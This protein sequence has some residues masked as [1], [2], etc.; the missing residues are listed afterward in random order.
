MKKK[1]ALQQFIEILE[2]RPELDDPKLLFN[3]CKELA[4]EQLLTEREQIE[5]A[6][7]HGHDERDRAGM[8]HVSETMASDYFTQTYEQ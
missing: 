8:I 1:T 5:K 6:V 3:Y 7:W 4:T 2:W